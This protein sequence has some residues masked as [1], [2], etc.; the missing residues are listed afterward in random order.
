[1]SMEVDLSTPMTAEEYAYLQDRNRQ[2]LIERSHAMHGTSDADY[3]QVNSGDGLQ[4]VSLLQGEARADR[5][6]RLREELAMLEGDEPDE[7]VTDRNY[8]DWSVE[9][10]N[11]ELKDR[12]LPLT[13]NKADKVAR[14]QADDGE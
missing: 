8:A 4:P 5:I 3:E 14:L 11:E 7:E 9:E 10:L 13:G 12:Q 6:N 2:D 1:M